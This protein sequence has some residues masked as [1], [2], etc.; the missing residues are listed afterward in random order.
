[1]ISRIWFFYLYICVLLYGTWLGLD[2]LFVNISSPEIFDMTISQIEKEG[3][4]EKRY[5][6]ISG[7]LPLF[8]FV[9]H[10]NEATKNVEYIIYP[11]YDPERLTFKETDG[12]SVFEGQDWARLVIKEEVHS[13]EDEIEALYEQIYQ[14]Y[15]KKFQIAKR[16]E[17]PT[18]N[19]VSG[20]VNVAL[21]KLSEEERVLLDSL[22]VILPGNFVFLEK[23]SKPR[24]ILLNIVLV[25]GCGGLFIYHLLT[26]LNKYVSSNA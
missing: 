9:Y 8:G 16:E 18:L 2:G 4:N 14:S 10:I 1:M 20:V 11:L 7:G 19:S 21:N 23:D 26:F 24:N 17:N 13:T 3:A 5:L 15:V 6:R 22:G 12:K 25:L